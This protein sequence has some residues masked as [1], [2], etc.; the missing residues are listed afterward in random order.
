MNQMNIATMSRES[1]PPI[2]ALVLAGVHHT[3]RPTWKLAETVRFYRDVMG[4][5]LVHAITARGWGQVGH[6]DF[7]HFFFESGK[8][9]TIAF[10]Y[11]IGTSCPENMEPHD[12]YLGRSPHTAWQVD[13]IEELNAWRLRL[14]QKGVQ[15][16]PDTQHE[17][18]TSIYF[19]DPN[20]YML[21][22]TVQTRPFVKED[23]SDATLTLDAAMR[24]EA[25]GARGGAGLR[26][27]DD[28][29]RAKAELIEAGQGL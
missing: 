14:E 22:I 16:S 26:S 24:L 2:G 6:P 29:W 7:L 5:P 9:S 8:G 19:F 23:A 28:V 11:Y 27:I 12:D 25:E 21:E 17:V 3:A 13:S 15:V 18:I 4:L 10:F 20:G 1:T